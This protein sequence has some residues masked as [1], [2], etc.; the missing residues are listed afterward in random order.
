MQINSEQNN[1]A[2]MCSM[3]T[4]IFTTSILNSEPKQVLTIGHCILSIV[5]SRQYKQY[6][7]LYKYIKHERATNEYAKTC[8]A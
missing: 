8:V 2:I 3:L 6:S 7:I 4:S 1:Y 5:I